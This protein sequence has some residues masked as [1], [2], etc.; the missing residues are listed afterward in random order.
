M[1][2]LANGQLVEYSDQGKGPVIVLLHGW[3]ADYHTFD[4]LA[5]QLKGF[6]ILRIDFPGFG[7]S[8]LP[9]HDWGVSDYAKTV[10]QVLS[11]L[12]I[13]KVH[14]L[15][16][17]SFGGRVIIK[18]TA[19]KMIDVE[20]II[21]IGTAGVKPPSSVKKTVYKVVAKSGKA[22]T[23]LPGLRTF[24][25]SLRK[26]LYQSAG[27]TDYLHAGQLQKVFLNVISEDLLPDVSLIAQPALL[28]WGENDTETPL[29][30]AH[31]I[32]AALKMSQLISYPDA[33]HFVYQE[34]LHDVANDIR[35]F[36]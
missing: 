29:S 24:R 25:D 33:G 36:L 21:L 10:Q 6:R 32:S 31:K 7:G 20:K 26:K 35:E 4:D 12:G 13:T 16:G 18:L 15:I 19:K 28:I 11:K 14:A 2:V 27:S 23:S 22:V 17:H 1:K 3:G 9:P 5:Q 8:S 30:D 34:K